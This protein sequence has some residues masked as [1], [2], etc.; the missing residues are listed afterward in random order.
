M[1]PDMDDASLVHT[2]ADQVSDSLGL[3]ERV[4]WPTCVRHAGPPMT[5]A[6]STPDSQPAWQYERGNPVVALLGR[7]TVGDI[8]PL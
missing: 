4:S 1:T 6:R 3:L 7:L 5:L 2:A 8:Q